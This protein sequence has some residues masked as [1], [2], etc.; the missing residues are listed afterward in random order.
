MLSAILIILAA[1]FYT[2][3]INRTKSIASGRKGPG[4]FQHLSDVIRLFKK[5]AV[6]SKT[7]SFI[8][9]IAPTIYFS[10]V[11][12]AMLLVPIGNSK[13]LF[14][15]QGDFIL[16]AYI[17]ALGKFFSIIAA[18]DT[19]SSF[20]GM[21]A[22]RE[23]LFSLFAEPA[24]FILMG[25]L[26]LL[27]GHTSFHEIF[28]ALHLGSYTTYAIAALGSFVLV[29]ISMVE[30][31]RMPIDDPKTHLELTMIHEV[32]ILD[33]SGFDLGLILIAGY[34]KFAI[35]AA[36]VFN[37]F[38]G[39]IHYE[40]SIPLFFFTQFIL[41]VFMGLVESFMARFRMSHNPQ[42]IMALSSVA[43]LIF[44]G[45]LLIIGKFI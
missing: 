36:I 42:F 4:L 44:F 45:V 34:L 12:I 18:L 27:T 20:E 39:T 22:S 17:L 13:G 19:G 2:G 30:N 21:G 11:V 38:V 23:A 35:Y 37:L 5:G 41:A 10:T 28:S 15:F 14:S 9:Q 24:F 33:N 6:Y 7:T 29:M 40:Y 8:F 1:I 32:M 25:S 26:A 31:S 3:I 43:L 16:F